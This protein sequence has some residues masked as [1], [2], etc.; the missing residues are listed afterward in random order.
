[1]MSMTWTIH[2]TVVN[3]WDDSGGCLCVFVQLSDSNRNHPVLYLREK[4][5]RNRDH[6]TLPGT[7]IQVN[8]CASKVKF[9]D[10]PTGTN[11][12]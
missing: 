12:S 8:D 9:P 2:L 10:S 4:H 6:C 1:M 7:L 5:A 11:K 3:E